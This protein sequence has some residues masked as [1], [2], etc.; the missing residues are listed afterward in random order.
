VQ[1]RLPRR[2]A[3]P[4]LFAHRGASAHAPENTLQAFSLA[5]RLG[6]NGLE[7]DAWISKDGSVVLD[8]DGYRRRLFSKNWIRDFRLS[9]L[10]FETTSLDALLAMNSPGRYELCIDVKDVAAFDAIVERVVSAGFDDRVY[11]CHPDLEVLTGW[12]ARRQG[13]RLV[14]STRYD[15][16]RQSPEAHAATL[17]RCGIDVC[18]MHH[19]D[20]NGGLVALYHRFELT[21]FAWDVQHV[22]VAETMLRMGIDGI[23]GDDVEVLREALTND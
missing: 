8:H 17:A 18:N 16:I 20:W 19:S 7:T 4:V 2:L 23:F 15:A 21:A 5:L 22:S 6:A 14:H 9:D 10:P 11:L 13:V 12:A 1:Q 3:E